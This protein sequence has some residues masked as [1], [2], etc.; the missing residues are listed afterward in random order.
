M[1]IDDKL[2][3]Y[4]VHDAVMLYPVS[5]VPWIMLCFIFDNCHKYPPKVMF[6]LEYMAM[7]PISDLRPASSD[8]KIFALCDVPM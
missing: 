1:L 4:S 2:W 3:S 6:R 7:R 5:R 8:K